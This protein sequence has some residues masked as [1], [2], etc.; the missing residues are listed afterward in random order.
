MKQALILLLPL[1]VIGCGGGGSGSSIPIPSSPE[2]PSSEIFKTKVID[3]YITGANIYIDNNWNFQQDE[4]EPSAYENTTDQFYY[5]L[6]DDFSGI[7]NWSVECSQKRPRIAEIPVGAIDSDRGELTSA[8]E[9]YYLPYFSEGGSGLQGEYRA[10]IT[11]LTTL[12]VPF[13][14][15]ELEGSSIDDVD[16]CGA[17]ANAIANAVL[18]KVENVLTELS[19]K[20]DIN[21]FTFYDDFIAS[22][23]ADL[24]A[25]GER[26]VDFLQVAFNIGQVIESEYQVNMRIEL[27]R[28]VVER[29]LE[30]ASLDS[31]TYNFFSQGEYSALSGGYRGFTLYAVYDVLINSEGELID[32]SGNT[33][34]LTIDNLRTKTRFWV[35][36]MMISD[37]D[38][39][40]GNKIL[41]EKRDRLDE[42][43]VERFIQFSNFSGD[44][45]YYEVL[46]NEKYRK[47]AAFRNEGGY[48]NRL[49][50]IYLNNISNPYFDYDLESLMASRD[51]I[52]LQAIWNDI[53][54]VGMTMDDID[55]NRYLLLDGDN[56]SFN[57][58][59]WSYLER[60]D[61][62]GLTKE[63]ANSETEVSSVGEEAYELC[64]EMMSG[65]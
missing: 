17:E 50:G 29:I 37:N 39:I 3:G 22:G 57:V 36:E 33:Y 32:T 25:Y 8:Y 2:P 51:I 46:E 1:M 49:T 61:S 4:N 55:K 12:F 65:E 58:Y 20:F 41:L 63:C 24:Q 18:E 45:F 30:K 7:N 19:R 38:L 40:E 62:S 64:V 13:I 59:P 14:S 28:Y 23:D 42:L 11:P 54:E 6:E 34:P 31:M 60:Q 15:S 9:M 26:I 5:F 27:S 48:L 56:Q 10:N 52:Q 16:G 47:V 43:G 53:K 35:R 44:D 21:V